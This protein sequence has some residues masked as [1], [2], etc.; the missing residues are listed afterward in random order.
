MIMYNNPL[1]INVIEDLINHGLLFY[2]TQA[3]PSKT[4][5][6]VFVFFLKKPMGVDS[7]VITNKH[8]SE[9]RSNPMRPRLHRWENQVALGSV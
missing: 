9:D 8:T 2:F 6:N 5:P 4:I 1:K 3:L 7:I